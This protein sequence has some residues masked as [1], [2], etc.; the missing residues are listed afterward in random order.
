MLES[1]CI[2][3]RGALDVTLCSVELAL[4]GRQIVEVMIDACGRGYLGFLQVFGG[5]PLA[6]TLCPLLVTLVA[7]QRTR[8]RAAPRT[9]VLGSVRIARVGQLD[10][11]GQ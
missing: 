11:L 5:V 6:A 4:D 8:P 2:A 1:R 10:P 9:A 3:E 7:W